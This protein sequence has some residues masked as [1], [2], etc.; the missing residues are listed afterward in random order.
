MSDAVTAMSRFAGK[1]VLVA[2]ATSGIG[3]ATAIA[4]GAEGATVICCG[5]RE[6]EGQETVQMVKAAG[7][8]GA[9]LP[10][11]VTRD[12]EVA[13]LRATL[14]GR[15]GRLNC[16]ANC[17]GAD[18]SGGFLDLD[19]DAFD[20]VFA[21][22]VRGLFLLMQQE[23][24]AM[25]DAGGGAIVNVGSIAGGRP[26]PGNSVYNASKSAM[27]MLTRS[28]A[29][30]CGPL[31]IRINEVSPGPTDTPMLNEYI[32]RSQGT[33][34]A[35]TLDTFASATPLGR[36]GTPEDLAQ[37]ILFLCSPAA[38]HVTGTV[39]QVDGGFALA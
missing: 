34:A 22:N 9:F 8:S 18:I 3:R 31:G 32:R 17:L 24:R 20:K 28:A 5:R 30:E 7:G 4:F 25:H 15:H 12:S 37:S 21:T 26:Y 35:A 39:L 11:D 19:A 13:A 16:A 29:V 33:P 23:V 2:G 1:V 38:S 10:L 36:V 6:A 27:R 14:I